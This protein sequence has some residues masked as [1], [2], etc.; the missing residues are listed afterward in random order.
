M[1]E[2]WHQPVWQQLAERL[3]A[4]RVPHGILLTGSASVGKG[5]LARNFASALLCSNRQQEGVP[6]GEC[7]SC[8]YTSAGSHPDLHEIGLE[9]DARWLKIDQIRQLSRQ[10]ALTSSLGRYQ[11]FIVNP[12]DRLTVSA[13]NAFLKTLEEP[14][15]DSVLL[16]VAE[17]MRRLP[18][19][20]L[21]RCQRFH[22]ATPSREDATQWLRAK[23]E[24][25]DAQ[26]DPQEITEAL[27]FA[28]GLPGIALELLQQDL[29]KVA[30]STR[31]QLDQVA[32]KQVSVLQVAAQWQSDYPDHRLSWMHRVLSASCR[33]HCGEDNPL[34]LTVGR[35]LASLT[36]MVADVERTQML[37]DGNLRPELLLEGLL[38]RWQSNRP[39]TQGDRLW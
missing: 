28:N 36:Q 8:R 23:T 33:A 3:D 10:A 1:L 35:D 32:R 22:V 9:E 11:V 27:D 21:S 13:A 15:A 20:I 24:Q 6:C 34:A 38:V 14:R 37:M 12:A 26:Q 39:D 17:S 19:T 30:R 4:D 29:L 18:I 16:L 2:L 5:Q 7:A 25:G 31:T